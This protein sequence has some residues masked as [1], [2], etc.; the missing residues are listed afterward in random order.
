MSSYDLEGHKPHPLPYTNE[1]K[2]IKQLS[3]HLCSRACSCVQPNHRSRARTVLLPKDQNKQEQRKTAAGTGRVW[4]PVVVDDADALRPCH[5]GVNSTGLVSFHLCI[6]QP[7]T[8]GSMR[9]S[10]M[11][12]APAHPVHSKILSMLKVLTHKSCGAAAWRHRLH[13]LTDK[14]PLTKTIQTQGPVAS[15]L[16]HPVKTKKQND[17]T[18]K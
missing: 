16:K 10:Q 4:M 14:T 1:N 6:V 9:G 18:D 12:P 17:D 13:H 7:C 5:R 15:I 2:Q 3:H 8:A 11:N